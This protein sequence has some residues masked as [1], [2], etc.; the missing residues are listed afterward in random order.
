VEP[1]RALVLK[2]SVAK[3]TNKFYNQLFFYLYLVFYKIWYDWASPL[4]KPT[5]T[6]ACWTAAASPATTSPAATSS[7]S[8]QWAAVRRR[9]PVRPSRI[10]WHFFD[11]VR[12]MGRPADAVSSALCR[13]PTYHRRRSVQR[14]IALPGDWIQIPEKREIR[15]VPDGHCWVE[16]DNAGHSWD[17][18]H[19]G[20]VRHSPMVYMNGFF[21]FDLHCFENVPSTCVIWKLLL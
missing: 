5:A 2:F 13:S 15:Q 20:P 7:F 1:N 17:S 16:G 10:P 3:I 18:R 11:L 6:S 4:S 21:F 12:L 14:L 8:G 19:Y 9:P